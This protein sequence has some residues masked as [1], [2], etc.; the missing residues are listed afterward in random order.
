MQSD[1]AVFTKQIELTYKEVFGVKKIFLLS[2]FLFLFLPSFSFGKLNVVVSIEPQK[3]FLEKIGGDLV[4]V[5]VMVKK[6]SNPH[7]YEPKPKD[8][9][10]ISEA[11]IYFAIGIEFEEIW[12]EKFASQNSKMLVVDSTRDINKQKMEGHAH[13]HKEKHH[14]DGLD[15][16]VWVSPKNVKIVAKNMALSLKKVDIENANKYE[17]N[18]ESFLKEIDALDK[19]IVEILKNSKKGAKFMVFHPAWGYFARDYGLIELAVEVD[20]KEPKPKELLNL[21]KEVKEENIKVIFTSPE[22]SMKSA[23]IIAKESGI[24]VVPISPL[25]SN[26]AENLIFFA[27]NIAKGDTNRE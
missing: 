13:H 9:K 23:K 17:K 8:M 3:E 21:I 24:E 19:K 18:L 14:E 20:G 16:H 5:H 26:W 11:N 25:S 1:C 2:L 15:P 6:G 4:D 27:T 22:F 12:L 7:T 10:T